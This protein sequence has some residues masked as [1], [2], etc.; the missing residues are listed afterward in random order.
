MMQMAGFHDAIDQLQYS[1]GWGWGGRGAG[2]C[3]KSELGNRFRFYY[4]TVV[5]LL[6]TGPHSGVAGPD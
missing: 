1:R 3:V 2:H 6:R 5:G 4:D